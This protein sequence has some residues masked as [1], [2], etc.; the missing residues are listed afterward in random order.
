MIKAADRD[1]ELTTLNNS[2]YKERHFWLAM[3]IYAQKLEINSVSLHH[4]LSLF[5]VH[6]NCG[7]FLLAGFQASRERSK[8]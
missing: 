4:A 6:T 3:L 8:H 5:L 7:T 2:A 1:V